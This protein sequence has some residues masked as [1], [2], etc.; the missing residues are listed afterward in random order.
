MT[1]TATR[2]TGL[3]DDDLLSL[4]KRLDARDIEAPAV[5]E[6]HHLASIEIARRGLSHGHTD[7]E[8]SKAAIETQ[9][10]E[11]DSPDDIEAPAG[12]EKAWGD[13]LANGGTVS[14]FLTVDGYVL[15]A[16]PTVS[17]V[18]VPTIMG[19]KKRKPLE[20]TI[21]EE[22]GK[23]VVYS[24]DMS[25]KFGTYETRDEAEERLRQIERFAKADSYSIPKGVQAA[26]KQALEWIADGKAGSGFTSTGRNRAKQLAAGG[27]V[28]RATLVKMRSYFARHAVDK[29]AKGWGDKSNPTPGM[30][31]WYA[32]GGN[33]GRS[34][35]NDVLGRV[36]KRAAP[37]AL[38][39]LGVNTENRQY[40]IDEYLYGPMNPEEP[41]SY[42]DEL[43]DVWG[44]AAETAMTTRCGNCAA[45][46]QTPD[47]IAMMEE[48]LGEAGEKVV[49]AANLGY[50]ELFEF[51]CAGA[52]TC[53]AWI[54]G[55]PI[56]KHQQGKH[57]QKSHGRRAT[58]L[59]P[60][61]ADSIISQTMEQGGLTVSMVDG[62][63]PP[64]G[65]MV[66]RTEGVKPAI[67][68]A[69]EFYDAEAGPKALG[70]FLKNNREQLTGG[71]YLGV[72]HEVDSGKVY[73]DVAQNV[74]D[75]ATAERLGRQRDQI[76]IWDVVEGKEIETG[77]T[78]EISKSDPI[79][80]AAGPLADDG[81]GDRRL[82]SG[83]L[84]EDSE[85][86]KHQQGKHDQ[87]TH[88]RGRSS[89]DLPPIRD[90][91]PTAERSPESVEAARRLRAQA[92][93][94]EPEF[95]SMMTGV[96]LENGGR[97]EHLEHRVKTTDSL[98]RKIQLKADEHNVSVDEAAGLIGDT[99]RY[100]SVF[101]DAD[102]V[103]GTKSVIETL[104]S[105]GYEVQVKDYW[106]RTDDPYKGV[107]IKAQRDGLMVELQT[108]TPG[109]LA[110]KEGKM[111]KLYEDFR[112]EK[113]PQRQAQ[114]KDDM[115]KVSQE[116]PQPPGIGAQGVFDGTGE[117]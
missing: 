107:N 109:S 62:S 43:G 111:H 98:A 45:F 38:T 22:D 55:G 20:K 51:K 80:E 70:S 101:P 1:D 88:G 102:Y 84:A 73:L 75:R 95:T 25:R 32:W 96:V 110:V 30:V 83:D 64:S 27:S 94:A 47:M 71:D 14:V 60:A 115:M 87:K 86:E 52:R 46:N 117:E 82:R 24:E 93:A 78:G 35:A 12:M 65:Y 61:V 16:D 36:E 40:A 77:G 106:S 4:H 68:D 21:R 97:L 7:D 69:S 81:R 112:Q 18:H 15:K 50:C 90:K 59:D 66:A 48:G 56:T 39:D 113:A 89:V 13:A 33:A 104:R 29:K 49:A 34:W 28:S 76:S 31:A 91:E 58:A 116:I 67:V 72:W 108:H 10:I 41:G 103:Q 79:G 99:V 19:G 100:T 26:A 9:V 44:V 8:W 17:D 42:W 74:S 5:V 54:G 63:T 85:V 6:A 114:L 57:D 23:F 3:S 11:V 92:V 53:A 2:L 105:E 37:E